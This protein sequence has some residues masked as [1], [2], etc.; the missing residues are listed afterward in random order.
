MR[1]VFLIAGGTAALLVAGAAYFAL[2][3]RTGGPGA[4]ALRPDDEALVARGAA[5]YRAHCASCHGAR[6]EG[7]ANWR[8]RMANGRLPAPPHDA[9]GHTWHHAD[10]VL[11]ALTKHGPAAM[12]GGYQS[13]MPGY[14]GV[15]SDEE[16]L[17]VLSYIKSRWPE[18]IRRRHDEI[19]A[20]SRAAERRG[21]G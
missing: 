18:Q 19:N 17:A 5:L 21:A 6:L 11:F 7:Q 10:A 3:D 8:A 4:L 15:L 16:I 20:R 14:A 9:S 12:V 2:S 1:P 13:D